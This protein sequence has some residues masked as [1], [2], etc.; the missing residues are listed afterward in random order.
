[1]NWLAKI[2]L[3]LV[4]QR[5]GPYRSALL[6]TAVIATCLFIGYRMGNYYHGYQVKMLTEQK[7]RLDGLY[8]QINEKSRHIQALEIELEVERLTHI[9]V[10]NELTAMKAEHYNVK[11]ELAFYEKVMAPEKQ[12][13]GLAID[14]VTVLATESDNHYRFQIALVQQ[15]L[16]RSNVKG[17][18]N[19]TIVGSLNNKPATILLADISDMM[20]KDRYFSFRYFQLINGEFNLPA[21]FIAEQ[22]VVIAEK[23]KTRWQKYKRIETVYPWPLPNESRSSD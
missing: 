18:V 20:K 22:I 17:Y 23:T 2:N 1:M 5:F 12:A 4:I 9:D 11:A 15:L 6:I 13:N 8:S 14:T 3:P 10:L 21:G 19:L 16:K 7:N